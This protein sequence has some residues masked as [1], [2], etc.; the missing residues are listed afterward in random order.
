MSRLY[1]RRQKKIKIRTLLLIILI[2][3]L[4]IYL[5]LVGFDF[6]INSAV[7]VNNLVNKDKEVAATD[8][9]DDDFFGTISLDPPPEATN[10]AKITLTGQASGF[11]IGEIYLDGKKVDEDKLPSDSYFSFEIGNLSEGNNEIFILAK[12]KDGKNKKESEKYSVLYKSS[13]P[14]LS[15][16]EP[17]DGQKFDKPDVE[18]KGTSDENTNIKIANFPVI[19]SS[20]GDFSGK[21]RLKQGENIIEIIAE[22]TAG[23]ITKLELKLIYEQDN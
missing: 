16:S 1:Q 13:P 12:T 22:D 19:S 10:S 8:E 11:E 20:N 5:F 2:P 18:I 6:L 17:S 9:N 7:F 15:V 4:A 3:L 21:V 23:N 14:S